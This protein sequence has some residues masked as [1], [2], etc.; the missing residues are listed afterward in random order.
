M[1]GQYQ[2]FPPSIESSGTELYYTSSVSPPSLSQLNLVLQSPTT[3][4]QF[5]PLPSFN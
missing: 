1:P 5:D 2:L 4:G 3:P